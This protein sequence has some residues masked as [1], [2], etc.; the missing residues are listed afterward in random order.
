M[1]EV[2]HA[3]PRTEW[4]EERSNQ[5]TPL[6]NSPLTLPCLKFVQPIKCK[7]KY[8]RNSINNWEQKVNALRH[9]TDTAIPTYISF[10]RSLYTLWT[11]RPFLNYEIDYYE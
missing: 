11:R 10:E 6:C 2:L 9:D 5:Q 1:P 7:R 3:K 8:I 4:P